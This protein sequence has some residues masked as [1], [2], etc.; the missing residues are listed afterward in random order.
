LK[1]IKHRVNEIN[2][3]I[4][5]PRNLGVEIDIRTSN[6]EIIISHDPFS[7]GTSFSKWLEYF[8]HSFLII[9]VKEDGLET[10]VLD[11]LNKHGIKNFFFLDQSMPSIFKSSQ[12]W[13]EF[14]CSRVSEVESVETVLNLKVG[15]VWFDS[16]SGD[17]TY[18]RETFKKLSNLN[19][20]KCLV[21]PELQRSNSESEL[22][23]L[24]KIIT[25]AEINFDAVCTKF[26]NKWEVNN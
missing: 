24:R 17:W 26:P 6:T 22:L 3:L 10:F 20:K 2:E 11:L 16:H 18:L 23:E 9:N 15:W 13:P 1:I 25:D 7:L 14:C 12:K 8:N 4:S 21:S 5:T 19:I